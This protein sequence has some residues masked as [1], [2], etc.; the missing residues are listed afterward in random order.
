MTTSFPFLKIARDFGVPYQRVMAIV[1]IIDGRSHAK[2]VRDRVLAFL[3]ERYS[4]S[5]S[6]DQVA[7]G[8][9]NILKVRPRVSVLRGKRRDRADRGAPQEQVR[10]VRKVLAREAS[11]DRETA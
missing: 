5:F 8:D 6:A 10:L 7:T 2:T 9:E 3:T 4:A 11:H 1:N